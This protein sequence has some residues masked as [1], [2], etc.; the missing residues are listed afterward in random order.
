MSNVPG[1]FPK[2]K[3]NQEEGPGTSAV[4]SRKGQL[5]LSFSI[6]AEGMGVFTQVSGYF[7]LC[8]VFHFHISLKLSCVLGL[9][10]KQTDSGLDTTASQGVTSH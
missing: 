4:G 2:G 10:P 6:H 5:L 8:N 1:Q 7:L 3:R 9:L